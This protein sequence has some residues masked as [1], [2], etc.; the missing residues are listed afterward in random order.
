MKNIDNI[1]TLKLK[2]KYKTLY[3]ILFASQLKQY[4][5]CV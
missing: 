3:E 2:I 5:E 1:L 4:L